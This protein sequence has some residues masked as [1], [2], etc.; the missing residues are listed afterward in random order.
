[1]LVKVKVL[2]PLLLYICID[3]SYNYLQVKWNNGIQSAKTCPCSLDRLKLVT[4]K[5]TQNLFI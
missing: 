4:H 2:M 5:N 1:M 3:I